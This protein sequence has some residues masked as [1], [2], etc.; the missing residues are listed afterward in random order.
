MYLSRA[1]KVLRRHAGTGCRRY[2]STTLDGSVS[3]RHFVQRAL[4]APHAGYFAAQDAVSVAAPM[5][6]DSMLGSLEF[7][8]RV[9]EIYASSAQEWLTPSE[10]F[11][12]YWSHGLA[13]YILQAYQQLVS[14]GQAT[15]ASESVGMDGVPDPA[16]ETLPPLHVYEI[17]AGTGTNA[18]HFCTYIQQYYPHIY[19]CLR[20]TIIEISEPL[21]AKQY[22]LLRAAG[23]A[24]VVRSVIGDASQIALDE[25]VA[26]PD[27]CFVLM[28]EVLDNLPH[29]KL[30]RGGGQAEAASPAGDASSYGSATPDTL[31]ALQLQLAQA[32]A[33]LALTAAPRLTALSESGWKQVRVRPAA[34]G[35]S[36]GQWD[37]AMGQN[38]APCTSST[39]GKQVE[40]PPL[41]EFVAPLEDPWAQCSAALSVDT[42]PETANRTPLKPVG[43]RYGQSDPTPPP[44]ASGG[45]QGWLQRAKDW[46]YPESSPAT[47]DRAMGSDI[48]SAGAV[49]TPTAALQ[50]LSALTLAL[51]R[52]HL[53]AAD[54]AVL[55][56]SNG[57][58]ARDLAPGS[59][60]QAVP[61]AST[62]D[63]PVGHFIPAVGE[64]LT[65]SKPFK[66]G[67]VHS[68]SG[69]DRLPLSA[70]APT[71]RGGLKQG[72]GGL[73]D[74]P[75]YLS[76]QPWGS[77]DIYFSSDFC[78]LQHMSRYLRLAQEVAL[79]EG[80]LDSTPAAK[81]PLSE[82]WMRSLQ[83][84]QVVANKAGNIKGID[85]QR[86]TVHTTAEFMSR[87]ARQVAARTRTLTGYNPLLDGYSN[88]QF[89]LVDNNLFGVAATPPHEEVQQAP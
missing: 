37:T 32:A 77:A 39:G 11:A 34:P 66:S 72:G 60:P 46:L 51:P 75:T 48:H 69:A 27:P 20:Y 26:N 9:Q 43:A 38:G 82:A 33:T 85:A 74:H 58:A 78:A 64:P 36:G 73:Y 4:Y 61:A 2:L 31:P 76:P 53:I 6:F 23:H 12:P 59:A 88:T 10:L 14:P 19:D 30:V 25:R 40:V 50:M 49:Y 47:C 57:H 55:P 16:G 70:T 65:V 63:A 84:L 42:R 71:N 28:Q 1:R 13:E 68:A 86:S 22:A 67:S 3:V 41:E 44:F 62:F 24:R 89:L 87:Y 81:L 52:H 79:R 83:Q 8:Q 29:D 45:L 54:F 21:A 80:S 5:K 56:P 17:G 15:A 18:L 7:R 35:G